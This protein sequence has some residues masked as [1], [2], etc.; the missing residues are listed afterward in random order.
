MNHI[1][2]ASQCYRWLNL[3]FV[4][5]LISLTLSPLYAQD[6]SA[7]HESA[8]C[9]PCSRAEPTI[10]PRAGRWKTWV[11]DS[12]SQ[13]RLA[14]PPRRQ[15][16]E[17]EIRELRNRARNRNAAALNAIS[18][19]D[20]GPPGYRW[21][22]IAV[23]ILVRDGITGPRSARILSLLN[24]AIYDA[25]IAAWDSKY[26]YNRQRPSELNRAVDPV[27]PVPNSPSYP[28]EH[29]VTASAAATVLSYLFPNE[30]QRFAQLA[31]ECSESR[32]NAGVQFPSDVWAGQ[33]LGSKVAE[34]V[35]AWGRTD[36]SDAVFTGTI[37][38]GPGFWRGT[39]P[40]QP[41]GGSWRT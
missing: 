3:L 38:T 9:R 15:A 31:L 21:N 7:E 25:T 14:P 29:A 35:I 26:A 40:L 32:L 5:I 27:I 34:L 2:F 18:F 11:L 36:G 8:R 33:S 13:F 16:Q 1:Y 12:G 10:E 22:E 24:V 37:P 6:F 39:N 4:V 28:S 20:S 41:T 30:A 23:N 19:W 17:D